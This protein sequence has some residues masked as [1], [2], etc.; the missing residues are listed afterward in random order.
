MTWQPIETAPK[1]GT[2]ILVWGGKTDEEYPDIP[3]KEKSRP[4]IAQWIDDD[5][6]VT[7][8]KWQFAYYNGCHHGEYMN[9]THWQPLPET[10]TQ[11][12]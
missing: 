3:E 2:W 5:A 10:L 8:H 1:D 6:W 11:D 12:D 4:V 9:P 7:D